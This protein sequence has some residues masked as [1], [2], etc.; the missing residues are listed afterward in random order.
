M[1]YFLDWISASIDSYLYA[2]NTYYS[3]LLLC[4]YYLR[5]TPTTRIPPRNATQSLAEAEQTKAKY[6][7][8]IIIRIIVA[9]VEEV[10]VCV[11]LRSAEYRMRF[12]FHFLCSLHLI[13]DIPA[14]KS[15]WCM[16]LREA[17]SSK[18]GRGR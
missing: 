5:T 14:S 12:Y 1:I 9:S 17:Y 18:N 2:N 7:I 6:I 3:R 8:I 10:F 13:R 16:R 4:T 15:Y 11:R